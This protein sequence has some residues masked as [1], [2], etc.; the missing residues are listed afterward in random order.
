MA[1]KDPLFDVKLPEKIVEDIKSKKISPR[2]QRELIKNSEEKYQNML[3]A[4]GE[5]IGVIAAQSLGEPGTQLT[6]RTFHFVGVA[7]LNV[8]TGLP[9]IIEILD[10][11]KTIKNK[12]MLIYLKSPHNKDKNIADKLANHIKQITLENLAEEFILNIATSKIDVKLNKKAIKDCELTTVRIVDILKEQVRDINI[13]LDNLKISI[14]PA[15]KDIRKVYKLKERIKK[16]C[17]AGVKDIISTLAVKRNNEYIIQTYGSN[18][19]SVFAIPEI[20]TSRT[21]SND[22]YEV[23]STFGIEAARQLISSEIYRVL[24]EEGMLVDIRYIMLIADTMC[25][26]GDL[27]GITRH[28]IMRGKRS[29][30]ARASFEIPLKHLVRASVMGEVDPLTS[31]VENIMINQPIP[32][33]T[34]LPELIVKVKK[35]KKK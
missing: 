27:K 19:K 4:P 6:M 14:E 13:K 24:E 29:V 9:R 5:A 35:R 23:A 21:T 22:L 17:I 32:I 25:K 16:I 33:G 10:A 7:E 26:D 30:L 3:I 2:H 8:T 1:T 20:D 28:G 31:V 15:D 18:L 11:K 12:V 34:G